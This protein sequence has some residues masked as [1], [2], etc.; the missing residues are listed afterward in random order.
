M[1]DQLRAYANRHL[2]TDTVQVWFNAIER[3]DPSDALSPR[4]LV[5]AK[6]MQFEAV[7]MNLGTGEQP[8][9]PP[10]LSLTPR[11]A[12]SLMDALFE[13]GVRPSQ[14]GSAGQL[15]ALEN[16][17]ADMRALAFAKAQVEAPQLRRM[18]FDR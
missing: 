6:P 3:D 9:Q 7:Q 5:T 12:Q 8:Y 11:Q 1:I 10:H 16:H 18:N 17:L 4:K 14:Q 13:C 2:P 15:A